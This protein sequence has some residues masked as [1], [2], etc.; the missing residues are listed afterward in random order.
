M[1]DAMTQTFRAVC[2][3]AKV[4]HVFRLVSE[5]GKTM[6]WCTK[7]RTLHPL[8]VL[9]DGKTGDEEIVRDQKSRRKKK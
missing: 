8:S 1:A 5:G 3:D 4:L 2:P 7:C 9:S 6:G